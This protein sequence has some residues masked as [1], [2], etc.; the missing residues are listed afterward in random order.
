M[1]FFFEEVGCCFRREWSPWA[2]FASKAP[3]EKATSS[4]KQESTTVQEFLRT[5]KDKQR[6]VG[7]AS[8]LMGPTARTSKL[9]EKLQTL[10]KKEH[11]AGGVL[12]VDAKTIDRDDH[13]PRSRICR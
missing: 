1:V 2:T 11:E 9:L 3:V 10:V 4:S 13:E 12:N 7:D 8:F 6:Y 5:I